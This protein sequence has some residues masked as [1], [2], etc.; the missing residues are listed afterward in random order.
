M[1]CHDDHMTCCILYA[2]KSAQCVPD[3]FL[4][5]GVE[6]GNETRVF[7]KFVKGAKIDRN[8]TLDLTNV[9]VHVHV[10]YEV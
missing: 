1:P 9:H 5:L 6:S 3:P 7:Y 2:P 10:Q 4:L 8:N